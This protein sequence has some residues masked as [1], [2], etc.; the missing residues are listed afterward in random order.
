MKNRFLLFKTL[1]TSVYTCK[2]FCFKVCDGDKYTALHR[3]AYNNHV[4]VCK[5]LLSVGLFS[6]FFP[7][8]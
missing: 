8:L 3:A 4:D 5:W 2:I 7:V 6:Q 1:Y